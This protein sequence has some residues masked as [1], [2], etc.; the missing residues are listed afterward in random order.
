MSDSSDDTIF[1]RR[2]VVFGAVPSTVDDTPT[3]RTELNTNST[4]TTASP[5]ITRLGHF[6]FVSES[7]MF[8]RHGPHHAASKP[9]APDSFTKVDMPY[10]YFYVHYKRAK[11]P[12]KEPTIRKLNA[13]K[14]DLLR[15]VVR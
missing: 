15:R 6:G 10:S 3:P 12:E 7:G 8:V 14:R 2:S 13:E 4:D 11:K 5:F 9:P 1:M